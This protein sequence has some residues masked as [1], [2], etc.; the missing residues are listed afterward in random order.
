M[1][2]EAQHVRHP[3]LASVQRDR[4]RI[5]PPGCLHLP[6]GA[7]RCEHAMKVKMKLVD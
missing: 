2:V 3:A 4:G 6:T 7:M 1:N 5:P